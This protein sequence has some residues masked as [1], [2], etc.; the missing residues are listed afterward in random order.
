LYFPFAL[1]LSK[2]TAYTIIIV[3]QFIAASLSVYCL[4]IIA[5]TVFKSKAM[6]YLTFYLFALSTYTSLFDSTLLTESFTCSFLIFAVFFLLKA[7]TN[8]SKTYIN[9]VFSGVF[10]TEVFFLRP[11]FAPLFLIFSVVLFVFFYRNKSGKIMLKLITFLLPFLLIDGAWTV[12]NYSKHDK[13][14]PATSFYYPRIANSYDLPLYTLVSSWGGANQYWEPDAEIRWFGVSD[15][16]PPELHNRSVSL[17]NYIYT[18]KFN[19]DSLLVLRKQLSIYISNE[20]NPNADS[21]KMESLLATIRAKCFLYANSIKTEKPFLYYVKAPIMRTKHFLIHS[22]TYNLFVTLT[23]QL[24]TVQYSIKILYSLFYLLII[25][26]GAIGIL[27]L[28]KQSVLFTPAA[29]LTGIIAYTIV[30]HPV[31]LGV[32]E[33]RYFVPAYPFML[34]CTVYAI[35][36]LRNKVKAKKTV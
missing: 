6:F 16:L 15:G 25:G 27:L 9:L 20:S 19:Y 10:L 34:I 23:S 36:W 4:A 17:P 33:K 8:E 11:V 31:I 3:L 28:F 21:V 13:F 14:I 12:R 35:N 32:C 18:S 22:G 24:N 26:F 2:A 5:Y 29:V 7:F 1:F 30:I